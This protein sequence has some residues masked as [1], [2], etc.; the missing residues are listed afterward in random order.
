MAAEWVV[1]TD[2]VWLDGLGP[3]LA[4]A[5]SGEW[6]E[7][8]SSGLVAYALEKS[9]TGN[10]VLSVALA[11]SRYLLEERTTTWL[12]GIVHRQYRGL[13]DSARCAAVRSALRYLH[14]D[15][16]RDR[17]RID[18]ATTELLR[19]LV[20]HDVIVL[21]GVTTF[22]WPEITREFEAAVAWAVDDVQMEVEYKE[23]LSVLRSLAMPAKEALHVF[24]EGLR[25]S[26]E[27][28][29]GHAVAAEILSAMWPED[30][31]DPVTNNDGLVSLMVSLA[32][33]RLTIHG[34]PRD[35]DGD[36]VLS[37]VF[38]ERLMYCA[39]CSRCEPSGRVDRPLQ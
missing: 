16:K 20:E 18:L 13:S 23:Y 4:R 11:V 12:E 38:G 36:N 37:M 25:F 32:P 19:F 5:V 21:N 29:S 8:V 39:G 28:E 27:N 31:G 17:E 1:A 24:W 10:Q 2:H 15:S 9:E 35:R 22:L 14:V 33:S 3:F 30:G 6:K 26:V 34:R 7:A